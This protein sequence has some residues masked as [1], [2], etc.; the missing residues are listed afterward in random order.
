NGEIIVNVNEVYVRFAARWEFKAA[1]GQSD[2]HQSIIRGT[3]ATLHIKPGHPLDLYVEPVHGVS[4]SEFEKDLRRQVNRLKEDYP[5]ISLH[6]ED[7]GWRI[8]SEKRAVA[9]ATHLVIPSQ[10]EVDRM[11]AKYYITTQADAVADHLL[12]NDNEEVL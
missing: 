8:T 10:L 7:N 2:T 6:Q 12:L 5:F 3:R 9:K 1:A 11:L 4:C